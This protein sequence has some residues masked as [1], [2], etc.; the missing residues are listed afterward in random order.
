MQ[1][2]LM[3]SKHV[4]VWEERKRDSLT[5]EVSRLAREKTRAVQQVSHFPGQL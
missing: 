4:R 3:A 5:N 1:S 2:Q